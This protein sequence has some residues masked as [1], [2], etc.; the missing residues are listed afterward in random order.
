MAWPGEAGVPHRR[1]A[2]RAVGAVVLDDEEFLHVAP[3]GGGVGVV[4]L[5][6]ERV[7]HHHGVG[8]GGID[9]TKAVLAVEAFGDEGDVQVDG[10]LADPFREVRLDGAQEAF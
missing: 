9:G 1:E 7:E 3:G 6:A 5:V 8:H 2:G 10:T 4:Q